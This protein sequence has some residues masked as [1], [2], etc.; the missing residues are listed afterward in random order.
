MGAKE[1]KNKNKTSDRLEFSLKG[2]DCASNKCD[3]NKCKISIGKIRR[4]KKEKPVDGF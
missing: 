4:E 2:R 3:C 1:K